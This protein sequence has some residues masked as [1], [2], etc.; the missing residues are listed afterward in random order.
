MRR[1]RRT[2]ST[3]ITQAWRRLRH[4]TSFLSTPE[5]MGN[6]LADAEV[7]LAARLERVSLHDIS[8]LAEPTPYPQ[9]GAHQHG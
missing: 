2:G 4:T 9:H 8:R 1:W 3:P 5:E 6:F 7:L